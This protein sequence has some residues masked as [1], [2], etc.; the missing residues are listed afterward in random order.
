LPDTK[1]RG[2]RLVCSFQQGLSGI[3]AWWQAIVGAIA[4]GGGTSKQ[5]LI[6]ITQPFN[7]AA[8]SRGLAKITNPTPLLCT[9]IGLRAILSIFLWH[10]SGGFF[11]LTADDASRV[12]MAHYW[13]Q[14]PFFNS[15]GNPLWLPLGIWVHGIALR[16]VDD[17]LVTSSIV[18]SMFSTASI[19]LI[20][21]ITQTLFPGAPFSSPLAAAVFAF[22]PLL[23]W[24]GLSGLSEPIFH[25]FML[26]GILFM[27]LA[28]RHKQPRAYLYAAVGFL[29]ASAIRYEAWILVIAFALFCALDFMQSTHKLTILTSVAVA[30]MFIPIWLY[31]QWF[32]YADYFHFLH[33]FTTTSTAFGVSP[34]VRLLWQIAPLDLLLALLGIV[35]SIRLRNNWQYLGFITF[36]YFFFV[37]AM[38]GIV[39]ANYPIRNLTSV[40]I[41][42]IP[43]SAYGLHAIAMKLRVYKTVIY[44]AVLA[45]VVGG[46]VQSLGYSLQAR[47]GVVRTAIWSRRIIHA[48]LLDE[49]RKILVE[50][51]RGGPN[52]RD[53]VWDSLFLH[54]VS[55]GRI[56][57]DRLGNWIHKDG[58]WVMN[59]LQNP[60]I[61]D[62]PS[63]EVEKRL[64]LQ[65]IRIVI[66]YS[67][68]VFGVLDAFMK[69]V[70]QWEEY[71]IYTWPD[72]ELI[73]Q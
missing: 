49:G 43:Y 52:E 61:L 47:D 23:V 34:Y 50:A 41:L 40:F 12:A 36:Y 60:S 44:V 56:V 53:I 29:G 71:R 11:W 9:I 4:S 51:R 33:V 37:V 54:A 7:I 67:K 35:V 73:T 28:N 32:V 31:W 62:G 5:I 16:F 13:S 42:L 59:E 72:D 69:P 15:P 70:N 24:L 30:S 46:T 3:K 10:R 19:V 26:L 58:E 22:C 2:L 8:H 57:Y 63:E 45:Y 39:A 64:R 66:A 68:P 18:N 55:P 21:K 27:L 25:F 6:T 17:P 65:K 48:G 38:R 20:Y 1:N 14:A